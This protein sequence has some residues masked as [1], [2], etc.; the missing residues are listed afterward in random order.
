[1]L[2]VLRSFIVTLD[3]VNFVVIK[4]DRKCFL[5]KTHNFSFEISQWTLE[6]L[7]QNVFLSE[8]PL[9]NDLIQKMLFF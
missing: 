8:L 5:I 9:N 3:S 2:R 4:A 1:M 7:K 6:Q